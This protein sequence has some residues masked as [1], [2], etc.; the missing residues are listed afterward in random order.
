[1][2]PRFR[3]IAAALMAA[4]LVTTF[5][6]CGSS[7]D[8]ATTAGGGAETAA[9]TSASG[10]GPYDGVEATLE[11][12]FK[13]PTKKDGYSFTVGYP[14][15]SAAVPALKAQQDAVKAEVERLGGKLIATDANLQVQK[16]VSDFEQLLSQDV[17]AIILSALDPNSLKPL[18]KKAK[19]QGV[20]VYA[21]DVPYKAGLPP[22]E[23]FNST[24]LTGTDQAGYQRA[25]YI[26]ETKPGAKFG[27]V[28]VG[29]PAPMLD[30]MVT[31]VKDW[32][33]KFGLKYVDRV[34]AKGDDPETAAAAASALLAKNKDIDVIF[35]AT[36]SQALGAAQ[37]A[38]RSG[39]DE[40]I[41][42]GNG[43]Y[44]QALEA[45][46]KGDIAATAW[47]NSRDLHKQLVWAA[48]ND[49]TEQNQPQPP[50]IVLGDGVLVTEA[51]VN[52]IADPI[53]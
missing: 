21:N 36:D 41:I 28:G 16:Q 14:N 49:L 33:T 35:A 40:V 24:S 32:G 51:N 26:A 37:A 13:E 38:K 43:G 10:G 22:I 17:D 42:V 3:N 44:K 18:L 47:A 29:I 8:G 45:I 20:K 1:M 15:P 9:A 39:R 11:T 2:K 46:K 50:Q 12:S 23:G 48:Y 31:S 4:G 25:K 30:Y 19:E 52:D 7:G 27:L 6:A 5:A 53:G 34:D